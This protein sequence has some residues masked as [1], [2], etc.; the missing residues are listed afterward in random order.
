MIAVGDVVADEV[1]Q[2][3]LERELLRALKK[4]PLTVSQAAG[5][6]DAP[7]RQVERALRRLVA[8]GELSEMDDGRFCG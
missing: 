5:A 6:V 2:A 8:V 7:V 3:Y 1:D 4:V